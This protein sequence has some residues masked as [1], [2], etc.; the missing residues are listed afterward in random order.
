[1]FLIFLAHGLQM[2]LDK[3]G[4]FTIGK[5]A[6]LHTAA[7]ISPRFPSRFDI[8]NKFSVDKQPDLPV[9]YLTSKEDLQIQQRQAL[10]ATFFGVIARSIA[11][12]ER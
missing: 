1:M 3:L 10:F 4:D 11:I 2:R 6:S 9:P 7:N 8:V 12:H 5:L